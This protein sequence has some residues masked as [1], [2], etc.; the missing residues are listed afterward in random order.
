MRR[1]A[2]HLFTLC[3]A[4]SLGLCI[5][6]AWFVAKSHP[7]GHVVG[8]TSRTLTPDFATSIDVVV[9]EYEGGVGVAF[10]WAKVPKEHEWELFLAVEVP[11]YGFYGLLNCRIPAPAM[12][13]VTALGPPTVDGAAGKG[14]YLHSPRWFPLVVTAILPTLAIAAFAVRRRR[15]RRRPGYCVSC[16]YDLRASPDRCPEC[17]R[18]TST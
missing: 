7:D 2:R 15:F 6:V 5:G 4:V 8:W 18:A 12:W 10:S 16:G 9:S 3:S 14:V 13:S 11:H 1:L 17:G